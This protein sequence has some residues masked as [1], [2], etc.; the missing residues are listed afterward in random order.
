MPQEHRKQKFEIIENTAGMGK[1]PKQI[2]NLSSVSGG[3]YFICERGFIL[4]AH[5]YTTLK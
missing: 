2:E 3:G 5:I 1:V 4:V